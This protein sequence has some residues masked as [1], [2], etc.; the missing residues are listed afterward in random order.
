MPCKTLDST[1]F[2]FVFGGKSFAIN[3]K[4]MNQGSVGGGNCL[5]ALMGSTIAADSTNPWI[6]GDTFMKCEYI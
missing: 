1:K 4:D 5:A 3:P 6:V 2:E